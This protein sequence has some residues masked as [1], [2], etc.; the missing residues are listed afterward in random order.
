[1]RPRSLPFLPNGREKSELL[2]RL[3]ELAHHL[4][5]LDS[6]ERVTVFDAIANT[7]PWLVNLAMPPK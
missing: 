6:V 7:F 3:K 1:M 5:H 4:A 2:S